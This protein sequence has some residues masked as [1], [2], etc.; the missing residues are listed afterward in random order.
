MS[1]KFLKRECSCWVPVVENRIFIQ[2]EVAPGSEIDG[3]GCLSWFSVVAT[4]SVVKVTGEK[5]KMRRSRPM[6]RGRAMYRRI[7]EAFFCF[8]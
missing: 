4:A 6:F 1:P 8:L 2:R 7:S 3:G 5:V